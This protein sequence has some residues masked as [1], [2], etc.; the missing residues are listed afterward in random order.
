MRQRAQAAA[1]TSGA[2]SDATFDVSSSQSGTQDVRFI[3][4][5]VALQLGIIA[6][7]IPD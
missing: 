4:D 3:T 5:D 7:E 1:A 6:P 2:T